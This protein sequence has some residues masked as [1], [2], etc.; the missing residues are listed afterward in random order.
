MIEC[1]QRLSAQTLTADA[2]LTLSWQDRQRSRIQART[3]AGEVIGIFLERGHPL[4]HGD[5][6]VGNDGRYFRVQAQSECLMEVRTERSHLFARAC[7]HLGNRHTPV[8]IEPGVI[9]FAPDHVLADMLERMGLD[10]CQVEAPFQPE[11]GAYA[12]GGHLARHQ[13]HAHA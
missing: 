9:R 4:M 1:Y 11:N 5:I 2:D 3:D 13:D 8:Q 12:R 10:V 7:Y 6:L